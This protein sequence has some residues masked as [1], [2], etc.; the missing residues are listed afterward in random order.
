MSVQELQETIAN[1]AGPF[2]V[3]D[4]NVTLSLYPS[5]SIL[6]TKQTNSSGE[7]EVALPQGNYSA[8]L[9]YPEFHGSSAFSVEQNYTTDVSATVSKHTYPAVFTDIQDPDAS[10]FLNPW[11]PVT[12]AV[13][14]GSAP[15][16]N[17][18]LFL[19]G[20]Y[21]SGA[22]VTTETFTTVY[23]PPTPLTLGS[24]FSGVLTVSVPASPVDNPVKLVSANP[25]TYDGTEVDWLTLQPQEFSQWSG[26]SSLDLLTYTVS[27][28]VTIVAT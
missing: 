27:L 16:L 13:A 10:G 5:N 20:S 15:S 24:N 9:S 6:Y 25:G 18:S 28:E 19:E 4:V 7:L 2:P 12:M 23:P 8:A 17:A 11:S 1:S 3:P 22:S 21:G 14:T 26:F